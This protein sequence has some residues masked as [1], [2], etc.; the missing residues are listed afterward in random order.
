M[1]VY[2]CVSFFF[3]FISFI[4]FQ[5]LAPPWF[6]SL[7]GGFLHFLTAKV[8]DSRKGI[9][10]R[11]FCFFIGYFFVSSLLATELSGSGPFVLW[12]SGPVVLWSRVGFDPTP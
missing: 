7:L 12:S 4:F 3:H 2:L 6:D 11:I 10:F 5:G 8:I 9:Y 1:Y